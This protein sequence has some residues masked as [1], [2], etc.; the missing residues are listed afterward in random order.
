MPSSTPTYLA[1]VFLDKQ[2]PRGLQ[3]AMGCAYVRIE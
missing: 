2:A 1:R 3:P